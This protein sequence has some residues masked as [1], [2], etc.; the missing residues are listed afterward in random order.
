MAI[1]PERL[2][3][4]RPREGSDD[5]DLL[6]LTAKIV[7]LETAAVV[8]LDDRGAVVR[9]SWPVDRAGLELPD[10]SAEGLTDL[11]ESLGGSPRGGGRRGAAAVVRASWPGDRAGLELPDFSAEGLTDLLESLGGS[12]GGRHLSAPLDA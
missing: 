1:P 3:A 11:L 10:F 4:A 12:P 9:A 2:P 5:F 6:R 8:I 7:G